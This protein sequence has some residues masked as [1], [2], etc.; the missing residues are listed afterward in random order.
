MGA[1]QLLRGLAARALGFAVILDFGLSAAGCRPPANALALAVG[2]PAQGARLVDTEA[3]GSCHILPGHATGWGEV[4]PPLTGFAGRTVIAGMLP[5]TPDNLVL[6][7][8]RPQSVV[9]GNGMP[10]MDLSPR[11]AHDI[12]AYLYTLQ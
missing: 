9:P 2:D 11:E 6:W 3:C 10:D 4:G 7:L 5:N 8:Q 12:A 1:R